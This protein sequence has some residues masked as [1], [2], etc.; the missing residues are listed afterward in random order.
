MKLI[1]IGLFTLG[2]SNFFV[3]P[4]TFLPDDL[5][6]MAI[7]LYFSGI[8]VIFLIVPPLPIMIQRIESKFGAESS[9]ASDMSSIIYT[10]LFSLGQ[11]LGPIY[12]GYMD[13]LVG[14]RNC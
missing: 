10:F 6:I 11:C 3:G 2:V 1:C 9:A 12:G 5:V 7:G 8:T 13:D 4:S 14:F